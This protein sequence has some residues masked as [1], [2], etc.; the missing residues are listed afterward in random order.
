MSEFTQ[1]EG[2]IESYDEA[3]KGNPILEKIIESYY[4]DEIK[5]W[6]QCKNQIDQIIERESL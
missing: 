2:E 4:S 5:E 3:V 1:I 6:S